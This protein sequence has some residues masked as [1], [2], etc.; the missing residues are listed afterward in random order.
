MRLFII[1]Q[2]SFFFEILLYKLIVKIYQNYMKSLAIRWNCIYFMYIRQKTCRICKYYCKCMGVVYNI[3]RKSNT[4][5]L[6]KLLIY[7]NHSQVFHY[8]I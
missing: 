1:L 7:M 5:H 4:V 3:N 6:R 8:I 2:H